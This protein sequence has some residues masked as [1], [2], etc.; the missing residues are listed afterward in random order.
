MIT[1]WFVHVEQI[2]IGS[3]VIPLKYSPKTAGHFHGT[4]IDVDHGGSMRPYRNA[5][6]LGVRL[7]VSASGALAADLSIAFAIATQMLFPVKE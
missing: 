2:E 6:N 5:R 4:F 3:L 7:H 1:H